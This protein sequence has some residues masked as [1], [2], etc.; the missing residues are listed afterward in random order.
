M[1]VE[2]DVLGSPSLISLMVSADVKQHCDS[3]GSCPGLPVPNTPYGFCGRR[4][5]DQ[6]LTVRGE[7]ADRIVGSPSW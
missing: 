7:P 1:K 4:N 5:A 2:V 6:A 3:R